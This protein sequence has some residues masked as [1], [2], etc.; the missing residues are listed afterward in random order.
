MGFAAPPSASFNELQNRNNFSV[1]RAPATNSSTL[2]LGVA[3]PPSVSFAELQNRHGGFSVNRAPPTNASGVSVNMAPP[4]ATLGE[5]AA[6][7]PHGGTPRTA[8]P[9]SVTFAELKVCMCFVCFVCV[10]DGFECPLR[11]YMH[12]HMYISFACLDPCMNHTNIWFRCVYVLYVFV[13]RVCWL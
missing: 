11:V 1:N 2:S 6:R 10:F 12:V 8:A 3:A 5:L 13:R 9:E 4:S 7:Q